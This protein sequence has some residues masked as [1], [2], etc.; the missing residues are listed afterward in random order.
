[1]K[2]R[3]V[4]NLHRLMI[5]APCFQPVVISPEMNEKIGGSG[6]L[7]WIYLLY[8]TEH[9]RAILVCTSLIMVRK[10][11][12]IF[13]DMQGGKQNHYRKGCLCIGLA[14]IMSRGTSGTWK[15]DVYQ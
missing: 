3:L 2:G 9:E 10:R 13:R 7:N 11:K 1:M 8:T 6:I 4:L 15:M 5:N 14:V 12:L